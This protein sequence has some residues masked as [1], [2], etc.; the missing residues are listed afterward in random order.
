MDCEK[1]EELAYEFVHELV[2]PDIPCH[3][4]ALCFRALVSPVVLSIYLSPADSIRRFSDFVCKMMPAAFRAQSLMILQNSFPSLREETSL[5]AAMLRLVATG[6][7]VRDKVKA[8]H[9]FDFCEYYCGAEVVSGHV[10]ATNR[11][12]LSL[13]IRKDYRHDVLS[14][15]GFM[16]HVLSVGG[17]ATLQCPSLWPRPGR[18]PA[19][20]GVRKPRSPHIGDSGTWF[21]EPLSRFGA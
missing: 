3:V 2:S 16:W 13:D 6:A 7:M 21:L 12:V 18:Y 14:A 15:G 9:L 8:D 20:K 1:L 5:Q 19:G 11:R 4:V 17:H 10:R